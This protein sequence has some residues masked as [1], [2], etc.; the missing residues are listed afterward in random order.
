MVS[1]PFWAGGLLFIGSLSACGGG[2]GSASETGG[3]SPPPSIEVSISPASASVVA[4]GGTARF[5]ATVVNSSDTSVIWEVNK[6]PGGDD[7][8]GSIASDGLY[9]APPSVPSPSAVTVS[10]IA[11][12]DSSKLATALVTVLPPTQPVAVSVS[13]SAVALVSGGVVSFTATVAN[14][15]NTGVT[16][17]VNGIVGGNASVGTITTG[18][19]YTAPTVINDMLTVTISAVSI[20]DASRVATAT[21]Y[22]N[23]PVTVAVSPA[24]ATA[25]AGIGSV[26]FSAM[27][28]NGSNS[29]VLWK[30]G[31]V[32]G[33]NSLVGTISANGLYTAPLA[34]PN[35]STVTVSAVSQGA[36]GTATVT[37]TP[38][39]SVTTTPAQVCLHPGNTARLAALVTNDASNAGVSWSITGSSCAGG[40]CG[41]LSSAV[42]NP[43]IYSA[44][45]VVS[46][47]STLAIT[48][49]SNVDPVRSS[50][51]SVTLV[52]GVSINVSPRHVALT[53]SQQQSF[54]ASLSNGC[55]PTTVT[56]SV[57][58]VPG[59][60][61]TLGTI[62]SNGTYL[63]PSSPGVHVIAATSVEDPTQSGSVTVAVTDLAAIPTY[64]YDNARTGQNTHEYALSPAVVH[65]G[66]FGK[67]FACS[68]DGHIY[69]EPLYAANLAIAGGTHNV[70]FV[71]TEHDSV[72]AFDADD[73]SCHQYW[74]TNFLAAGGSTI[75]ANDAGEGGNLP[76]VGITG[77]PVLDVAQGSLFV[78]AATKLG[79]SYFQNL[80][81]LDLSSGTEKAASPVAITGS[82]TIAF[83]PL[84]EG[85]R[86]ALVLVNNVVY[87]ASA[88]H[89]DLGAYHGIITGF[90]ATSLQPVTAFNVTPH[91]VQGGIWMSG[92]GPA[93]DSAGNLFVSS[94]NGTFDN[95]TG[96]IPPVAPND[97][98]GDSIL[99][100]ST[101]GGLAL[102]G[103]FTPADQAYLQQYDYDLGSGGVVLLPDELGSSAHPH[104]LLAGDK[105]GRLYLVD[106]DNLG[107]YT[108]N[109][110]DQDLQTIPVTS[111]TSINRSIFSTPAVW[112]GTVFIAPG[113]DALKAFPLSGASLATNPADQT[114]ET[115][116]YMGASPVITSQG[117]TSGI[118]WVLDNDASG[119]INGSP[120]GPAILRAYDATNLHSLLYS[121]DALAAD[122]CGNA[123]KFTVPTI[124]NGKVYVGGQSQMT[125]YG[126][127]P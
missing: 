102:S 121:S 78:V 34:V 44:P 88:S 91:G 50:T 114:G 85:Q 73:P 48:A 18:G 71:A 36:V 13:P 51:I 28:S 39:I 9:T 14:T 6:V 54:S 101:L 90:D 33:G 61:S 21:I 49:Q 41:S 93:A 120:V 76:E 42:A 65:A 5:T 115:Q 84:I 79:T 92:S 96:A 124:A 10:A 15:T 87:V 29:A 110:P 77:T 40:I 58:G 66:S 122:R 12:A 69:A 27:V 64:H 119:P 7:V 113:A 24:S 89:D 31:N 68:V 60:N 57:D 63:P 3:G 16:W 106:R 1:L 11:H 67:L 72:Y 4:A 82:S 111:A 80:H 103:F 75:P 70:I 98:L 53:P 104:L 38:P 74:H 109:G 43:V 47:L 37:I 20:A 126:L 17:N 56:W 19:L 94:G 108:A 116:G 125:V 127:L 25:Q 2:G 112:N 26:Q 55:D 123:I 107:G 62:N 81:A 30:I 52:P 22:V 35:S 23:E 99:E 118:V 95:F 8:V 45:A 46:V 105:L 83:N 117:T 97:D 32:A 86:S 100:L 59:G